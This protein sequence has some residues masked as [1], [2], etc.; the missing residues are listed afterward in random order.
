[1]VD[2]RPQQ[3]KDLEAIARINADAF[4]EHGGT[5]SFD[6]FR[7]ER[8]DIISLVA[9]SE[10]QLLGHVLFS[11]V[12]LDTPDGPVNGMGLGQ[13]AVDPVHQNQG[14]GTKL[15]E[16]GLEKLRD[17]DCPFVIVIGHAKYYPRFGFE[18][19][20]TNNFV[21]QWEGIPDNSFMV[22]FLDESRRLEL[23]G[24]ARFDGL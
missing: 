12:V 23:A 24:T 1:M 21:C 15:S 5:G 8:T 4:A 19:G 22:L 10:G 18:K 11:P 2:I 16:A 14:I 13:L 3:A 17:T 6:R 9:E 20:V 7:E